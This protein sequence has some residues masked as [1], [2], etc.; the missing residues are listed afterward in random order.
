MTW[1]DGGVVDTGLSEPT[2]LE[3]TRAAE[4]ATVKLPAFLQLT[5]Q[6]KL[7]GV[8]VLYSQHQKVSG[9]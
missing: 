7:Y 2:P 4:T 3:A 9:H 8:P 1:K 5:Q 6:E